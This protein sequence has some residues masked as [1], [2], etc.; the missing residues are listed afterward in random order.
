MHGERRG[1]RWIGLFVLALMVVVGT[2]VGFAAYNAGVSH[3]LAMGA[4]AV[5]LEAGAQAAPGAPAVVP[6]PH[7]YGYY[8]HYGYYGWHPWGFG[9]GL[10]PLFFILVWFVILRALFWRRVFWG[11]GPW[12]RYAYGRRGWGS[13]RGCYDHEPYDRSRGFDEWHRRAHERMRNEPPTHL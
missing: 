8:G 2:F 1:R 5:A 13:G 6:P 12:G 11:G 4:H 9:F 3:G 7:P 10:G